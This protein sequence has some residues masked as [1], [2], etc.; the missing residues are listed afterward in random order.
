LPVTVRDDTDLAAALRTMLAARTGAVLVLAGDG[1]LVGILTE[2]DLLMK[3][4]GRFDP[5][6]GLPVRDFMTPDP[7]AVAPNDSLAFALHK[8][9]VGGYRHLPVVLDGRPEG[10]IS[11]RDIVRHLTRTFRDWE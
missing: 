5:F 2:R 1:R 9:D 8:M 10:V 11:A 4:I 6:D 3:A 7:V